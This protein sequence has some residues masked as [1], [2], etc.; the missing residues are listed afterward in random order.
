[1]TVATT[2][3]AMLPLAIGSGAG[4]ELYQGLAAVI[5]GGLLLSTL[6]TLFLVPALITFGWD[7]ED[8]F[9]RQPKQI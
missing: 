4:A 3:F 1:M 2:C 8:L 5:L 7:V 9:R 6:F